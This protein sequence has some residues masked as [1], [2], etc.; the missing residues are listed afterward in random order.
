MS[1]SLLLAL[2]GLVFL[3]RYL[4]LEPQVPVKLPPLVREALKYSAPC[5]LTALCG[6][7]ILLHDGELRPF[8]ANP[9]LWGALGCVPIALWVRS[10][11]LA[12]AGSLTLFY[13]LCFW[14][15]F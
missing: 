13:A 9:Y 6:P 7:V 15:G 3:N 4:F 12:V 5:L 8:P 1:W 14:W 11:L 2:A 10:T